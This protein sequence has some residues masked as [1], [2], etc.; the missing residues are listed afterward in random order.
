MR[1]LGP[2]GEDAA[3]EYLRK[4]G[5]K[6]IARNLRLKGGELDIVAQDGRTLVFV[7]VKTR[8]S[9]AFGGPAEAVDPRKREKMR[10]LA[11]RYVSSLKEEPAARF[12]V[13]S[14]TYEGGNRLIEHITDAFEL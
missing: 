5:Y 4:K 14:I 1:P 8:R 9:E 7:E 3:S 12:D 2:E 11:L 13:V 10:S 6:I